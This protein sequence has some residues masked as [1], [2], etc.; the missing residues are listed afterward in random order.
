MGDVRIV[1]CLVSVIGGCRLPAS[2][3]EGMCVSGTSPCSKRRFLVCELQSLAR[4][5]GKAVL[6][7]PFSADERPVWLQQGRWCHTAS[8]QAVI[9]VPK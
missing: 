2:R 3:R 6:N 1:A 8:D 4:S 9:A 7:A 5:D